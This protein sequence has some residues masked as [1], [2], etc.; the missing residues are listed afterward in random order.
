MTTAMIMIM[1]GQ[2]VVLTLTEMTLRKERTIIFL[3][4]CSSGED[5][6]NND[7]VDILC[8]VAPQITGDFSY[9]ICDGSTID[10][11]AVP[12]PLGT[13]TYTWDFGEGAIPATANGIGPHTVQ[14]D[15]TEINDTAD[16]Q[17]VLTIEKLGCPP[18]TRLV[19]VVEVNAYPDATI[20]SDL[21]SSCWY[22]VM[23]FE[24]QET[25]L[26]GATYT[27]DFGAG[28]MPAMA[29]GYGPHDVLYTTGGTK[30]GETCD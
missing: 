20:T 15:W 2:Q 24:P 10:F 27:W 17:V 22:E 14:F 19:S 6:E 8:P 16:A 21:Q 25:E 4:S 3:L 30:E 9:V 18:Q 1:T 29:T 7:F 12:Q 26:P 11:E 13:E 28:A 23:S 5:D